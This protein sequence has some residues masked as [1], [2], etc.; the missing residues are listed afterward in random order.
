MADA[1]ITN[2]D[3][4]TAKA[5]ELNL[6]EKAR[7]ICEQS[8]EQTI[9]NYHGKGPERDGTATLT[10]S[11]YSEQLGMHPKVEVIVQTLEYGD[12]TGSRTT[13]IKL[14][15]RPLG[16]IIPRSMTVYI[17][18]TPLLHPEQFRVHVLRRTNA[19]LW[20]FDGMY[21]HAEFDRET[22]RIH[23]SLDKANAKNRYEPSNN[24]FP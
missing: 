12:N 6:E 13:R 24:S 8:G 1:H 18:E 9:K 4:K 3:K 19:W 17:S 15:K 7:L 21:Q 20:L 11:R 14:K 16:G 22:E 10:R 23:A 2:H 5:I